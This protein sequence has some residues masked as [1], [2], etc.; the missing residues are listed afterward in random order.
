MQIYP[1]LR[2]DALAGG[3]TGGYWYCGRPR[4]AGPAPRPHSAHQNQAHLFLLKVKRH[5]GH[6]KHFSSFLASVGL[7]HHN[8]ATTW[9]SHSFA[10]RTAWVISTSKREG[11]NLWLSFGVKREHKASYQLTTESEYN[12]LNIYLVV[13][14]REST[15][16]G[17]KK[18]LFLDKQIATVFL[19]RPSLLVTV[20][21]LWLKF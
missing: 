17:R 5:L 6:K 8:K 21:C 15:R 1:H 9:G 2:Q 3:G 16:A 13:Q 19:A 4:L 14:F 7:W 12:K 18:I 20:E 10:S 11:V